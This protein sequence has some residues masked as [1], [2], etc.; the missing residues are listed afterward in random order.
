MNQDTHDFNGVE[1]AI[2]GMAGRFPQADDVEALWRNVC[3][4]VES[5]TALS[6][7]ALLARGVSAEAL[8]DPAYV[9]KGVLLDDIECFDAAHFGYSPREAERMDPQHRLLLEIAWQA[10]EHAGYGARHSELLTGIYAGSGPSLYLHRHLMPQIDLAQGDIAGLLGLLNGSDPDALVTRIAYKLDLK[11][12]A[13]AVQTACSTSLAAV[14]LACRGLLN[15]EA[16][17]ALA[18]GVWLNLLQGRGYRYQA[19]AILSPDGHC[20]PFDAQAGGTAIGSGAGLVVLKRLAD[21]RADGDTIHA[22]I[23]GSA[24][25]NDGADKIG[26]TAP[27]IAGQ[28]AVIMAAHAMAEV[29]PQSIGYV[30][31]HGTATALGDP[32]EAAALMQAFGSASGEPFCAIGSLK[33]NIGHLDAAAGVAG[34]IKTV[35]AIRQGI[36]PPSLNFRQANAQITFSG[37]PF[38]VNTVTQ[39]WPQQRWPRRAGVSSFG[40][41]GTNVHVVLEQA[42]APMRE[43]LS[44]APQERPRLLLLS[45]RTDTALQ[46]ICTRLAQHLAQDDTLGLADVAFTLRR[47]RK[48]LAHRAAL[49]VK[50]HADALEQLRH[51]ATNHSSPSLSGLAPAAVFL[52]P[53]QGAQH[54]NMGRAAYADH[55]RV[56]Q[57]VDH[58]CTLL[59]PHLGLDLRE[60]LFPAPGT[61]AEAGQRLAQTALTQPALFVVEYA[62]AQWWLE[63]GVRPDAMLGH[64]IG[65]YVAAT[66]AGVFSLEDA[67]AVI[68]ARGRLLQQTEAGSM[69]SVPLSEACLREQALAGCDLAAVNGP[70]LCVLAGSA[71]AIAQAKATLAT[72][73]VESR[74]LQVSHAFHS[75]RVEPMLAAFGELLGRVPLQ[76]PQLPFVSNVSGTWITEQQ[77]RSPAYW[78]QHV[79]AT[80]RFADGLALLAGQ[81]ARVWLEVGPGDTLTTLTR[82]HPQA[83]QHPALASQRH[84]RQVD[85]GVDPLLQCL[86]RLFTCGLDISHAPVLDDIPARRVPLPTYPFAR[87]PYWI[88]PAGAVLQPRQPTITNDPGRW[89]YLPTWRRARPVP[90]CASRMADSSVVVVL[91]CAQAALNEAVCEQL[92]QQGKRVVQVEPGRIYA[93]LAAQR[94]SRA[95]NS[96]ADFTELFAGVDAAVAAFDAVCD[97][98]NVGPVAPGAHSEHSLFG[99]LAL[100]QALGQY[101][102]QPLR[103]VVVASQLHQVTGAERI[104]SAKASLLGL[105]RVAP[106]EYPQLACG[107]IDIEEPTDAHQMARVGQQIADEIGDGDQ[108]ALVAYRGRQRWIR[109]YQPASF[110]PGCQPELRQG[111]VYLIT[112]GLGG[113]GLALARHLA[114]HWQA[115]L[116]LMGRTLSAAQQA[117]VAELESLGAQVWVRQGDV[118]DGPVVQALVAEIVRE[119]GAL[120][121]VIHA[122]GLPGGGLM[123]QRQRNAIEQVF[124]AKV[125]GA[126]HVLTAVASHAPDFVLLCSSMSAITG[127]YG[128]ADYCAANC[129]LDAMAAASRIETRVLSVNWDVWPGTGMAAAL[130]AEEGG[131]DL[132]IAPHQAGALLEQVLCDAGSSQVLVSSISLAE[133]FARAGRVTATTLDP[134]ALAPVAARPVHARPALSTPYVEPV[135]ELERGVAALWS[136][137][138]GITPVG[139]DD[140]LFE[141]GGDSLLAIQLLASLRQRYGVDV[142]PASFFQSP[143]VRTLACQVEE[144]LI[145]EIEQEAS[146]PSDQLAKTPEAVT[147]RIA[148]V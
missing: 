18:G 24:M 32:I 139:L 136:E 56:R 138:L 38:Y 127:D 77:A 21:A 141:L 89:L 76:A 122:A 104:S 44:A 121:G 49:L 106:L 31:A 112:G 61:E 107:V 27:S 129:V 98:S 78:V 33:G 91:L 144:R 1:I 126:H 37:S 87:E 42:P 90:A 57:V 35:Q 6:E 17:L 143:T 147:P 135:Q 86:G 146:A 72:R 75:A 84:P 114:Q 7:E 102:R 4:G 105:C 62:L 120:H 81:T 95:G 125:Q 3:A 108:A 109:H 80:V 59:Q 41:G 85:A 73:G 39:P 88:E 83:S 55:P 25:N 11:G 101:Q 103:L 71:Q 51:Q 142:Q 66:L 130:R 29:S 134:A 123:A 2:I 13:V 30:E 137:F 50:G 99:L 140:N 115:R 92:R 64:S 117:A 14:H 70:E 94:F 65:E 82:R 113:V 69:L 5:V 23:R 9:C 58:C 93:Q 100:I 53:G 148:S 43:A 10:L 8:A 19:G 12:P 36:L 145:E 74:A 67:L 15:H 97:L 133:Q 118:T 68:A 48:Q 63:Q 20:R 52:F 54:A 132:G 128:Q 116:V 26:Y 124:A 40:M 45:A 16:D 131:G 79:R 46:Q 28:A 60:L 96:R 111:G 47:G 110:A 34:L 22:V 119:L